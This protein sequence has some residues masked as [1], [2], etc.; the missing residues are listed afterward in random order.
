MTLIR[1][2]IS[3]E[4]LQDV[5]L[6]NVDDH[7][8][9]NKF[10]AVSASAGVMTPICSN[11]IYQTPMASTGLTIVSDSVNDTLEG[12][13]AR[14]VEIQGLD[15]N[16]LHQIETLEMSGTTA[17]SSVN[18]WTRLYRM[19][20]V[21]TGTYVSLGNPF[22]QDGEIEITDAASN[23]WGIIAQYNGAGT[24]LGQSQIGMFSIQTGD[25]A[26]M[27]NYHITVD[28]TKTVDIYYFVRDRIDKVTAPYGSK[29]LKSVMYKVTGHLDVEAQAP[30]SKIDGPAD[31]GFL[32]V[33]AA[34]ADVSIDY[35]LVIHTD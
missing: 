33:S 2:T 28:S 30:L 20:V 8:V 29:K 10:G 16:W 34:G 22:S 17:V 1:E 11:N 5:Q 32:C 18:Q 26:Q 23:S 14:T 13:G 9:V 27:L 3:R 4:W 24:G 31:I 21:D 15:E 25:T 6:G 19:K 35:Q 12:T 7:I